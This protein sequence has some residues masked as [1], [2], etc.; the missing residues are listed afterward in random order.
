[1]NSN[2]I[3]IGLLMWSGLGMAGHDARAAESDSKPVLS[4]EAAEALAQAE[5][6]VAQATAKKALWTTAINALAQATEAAKQQDNTAVMKYAA[7]AIEQASLGMAQLDFPL[8]S[9]H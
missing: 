6:G 1:M 3:A 9:Q 8:T 5:S 4:A 7:V 2:R